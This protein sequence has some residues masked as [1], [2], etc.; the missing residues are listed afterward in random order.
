[1]NTIKTRRFWSSIIGLFA[2]V[3]GMF[4][5]LLQVAP[6]TASH[7]PNPNFVVL[8]GSFQSEL[9]CPG[10]W[11]PDC[12]ATALIYDA[13]D[14]VW[15]GS[16]TVPAGSWEYKAALNHSWDENYGQNATQ[17][18][19]NLS[20]NLAASTAVKFY[21]DH[22]SHW[23]TDNRNAVIATVPGSFQSELGCPGDW[24]PDCLRSW[25]QDPDGNGSY[26]FRTSALPAGTYEAK[27]AINESWDENYGAGGVQNGPNIFFT[28]P[29]SGVEMIF[30]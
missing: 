4:T 18:G 1:M 16:W 19:P 28:V 29:L 8:P 2:L 17:N 3:M 10:D 6:V 26:E 5:P 20:L 11:Q 25:L 13:S 27:V 9:G 7:T 30:S 22:K 12:D 14:A 15:Q 23:I 24:Q 21:Y